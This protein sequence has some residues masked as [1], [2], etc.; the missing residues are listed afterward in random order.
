[1]KI[2]CKHRARAAKASPRSRATRDHFA[3]NVA[4]AVR[5]RYVSVS[6]LAEGNSKERYWNI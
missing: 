2:G 6:L 5:A 3:V 1:M 4:L